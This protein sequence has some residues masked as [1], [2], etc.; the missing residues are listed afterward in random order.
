MRATF[1]LIVIAV[2]YLSLYPWQF[3]WSRTWRTMHWGRTVFASD[4][5]DAFSNLLFYLPVGISG[6][7]AWRNRRP[8][9]VVVLGVSL[10]GVGL[11]TAIEWLQRF[12]PM[13]DPSYR[14]VLLNAL[15]TVVGAVIGVGVTRAHLP[16][17]VAHPAWKLGPFALLMAGSWLVANG[18][19]FIPR[20]RRSQIL[21]SWGD[22]FRWNVTTT[23]VLDLV[24][25]TILLWT[26]FRM[27]A[28]RSGQPE[29]IAW[30][31]SLAGAAVF[32]LQA[33]LYGWTLS[34]LRIAA[35]ALGLVAGRYWMRNPSLTRVRV[36][37]VAMLLYL[38]W[39]EL[40]PFQFSPVSSP[41]SWIP[42]SGIF[43]MAQDVYLR[44]IFGKFFLYTGAIWI[45]RQAGTPALA[46]GAIVMTILG[47]GEFAQRYLPGRSAEITDLALAFCGMLVLPRR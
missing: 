28:G 30:L 10:I 45:V 18:Y 8:L 33:I 23:Q 5:V 4:W 15:G 35:V 29:R 39:R 37:A 20:L 25:G 7:L 46:A 43:S 1:A 47:A 38:L 42:F 41:F 14:D 31:G 27:T 9:W 6:V 2:L 11:T 17:R 19:P 12:L 32:P 3:D 22:M 36:L 40:T 44:S 21:A 13:R 16:E 34:A 26:I 24:L